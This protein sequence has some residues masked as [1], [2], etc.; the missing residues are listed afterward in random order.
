MTAPIAIQAAPRGGSGWRQALKD[1]VRDL[2]ELGR[3][4]GL[5]AA[6]LARIGDPASGFPMLIPRGFVARMEPGNPRDPLL[7]QVLPQAAERSPAPGF[8]PDP[9]RETAL[10][11]SGVLRKYAARALLI[12]TAACPV[13]CRYCF[14]REFPYEDQLASRGAWREA[15]GAL[16]LQ[17]G[18]REV[19]LSGGDPLSLSN[20]RIAQLL[21][22]IAELEQVD[23][24]RI[25]TRFPVMVPE[26]VDGEL[27]ALLEATPLKVVTVVHCNHANELDSQV[28]GAL[29][30]LH[31]SVDLLLNQAVLLRGVNDT[32]A[33]LENLSRRLFECQVLPYYLHM[34]DPVVGT[35]HFEVPLDTAQRLMDG[36]RSRLPG[37]LV[38]RLVREIPGEA[39][40]TPV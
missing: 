36:L 1:A 2:D 22:G 26:R 9:L 3:L 28:A 23:C 14:R 34:L 8:V 20:R 19:I 11:A 35:A 31:A 32:V 16:A 10:A 40:K 7:L 39:S 37:Y 29:D 27:E 17:P 33:A 38:P 5:P 25:H 24:V 15:L 13:H 18:L 30:R 4:L 6:E 12:S 21:D